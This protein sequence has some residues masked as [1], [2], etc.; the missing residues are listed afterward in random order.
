[1]PWWDIEEISAEAAEK[2]V[3]VWSLVTVAMMRL[4]QDDTPGEKKSRHQLVCYNG[5]YIKCSRLR[6][7]QYEK[8]VCSDLGKKL[9]FPKNL[10]NKKVRRE[11]N[12]FTQIKAF[13]F[14]CNHS[15]V[16]VCAF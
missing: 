6:Q 7:K 10:K 9:A 3:F 14:G 2:A 16:H 11:S 12:Q 1:M 8:N 4:F 13:N 5:G 15:F